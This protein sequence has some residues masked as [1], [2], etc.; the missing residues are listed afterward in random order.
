MSTSN[1]IFLSLS[2]RLLE[3]RERLGF[4]QAKL[5][6][7]CQTSREMIG[8]YEKGKTIPGGEVLYLIGQ[9]GADV[10]YI[11]TGVRTNTE[12]TLSPREASLVENYRA[13]DL[14]EDRKAIERMALRSAEAQP[15]DADMKAL[16]K[17]G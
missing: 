2:V 1:E 9:A 17:A 3:E 12:A 13:C 14:E 11:L 16:K 8:K 4:S 5:A 7:L 15:R 10:G 6:D